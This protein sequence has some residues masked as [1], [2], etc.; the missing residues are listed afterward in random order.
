[1]AETLAGRRL[2]LFGGSFNPVH[3]GHLLVARAAIE[4][5]A[6]DRLYWIPAAQSPFKPESAPAPGAD[7]LC[8]LRLALAGHPEFEIDDQE[9]RRGGMS[10]TIDTVRDYARRFPDAGLVCLIG[11]DHVAQLPQWREAESLARAAEWAVIP[12]PGDSARPFPPPF[13]GR[14]LRGFPLGISSSLI[15]DRVR[16]GQPL[17]PLVPPAVAEAIRNKRLYL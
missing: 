17:E 16:S 3:T 10:Y 7:R 4:E 15:R 12:R 1:M 2:G 6:I 9:I 13:R 5:L 11:A 8:L 14:W